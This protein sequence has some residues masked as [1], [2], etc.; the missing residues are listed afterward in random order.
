MELETLIQGRIIS[1]PTLDEDVKLQVCYFL[2][3]LV[4]CLASCVWRTYL[5]IR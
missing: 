2:C 5:L 4:S 1:I 3:V